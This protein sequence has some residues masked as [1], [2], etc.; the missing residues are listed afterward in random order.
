VQKESGI[1][2]EMCFEAKKVS[3]ILNPT[4]EGPAAQLRD[5]TEG[6]KNGAP[7]ELIAAQRLAPFARL[8]AEP[9]LL[10]CL[11]RF[12]RGPTSGR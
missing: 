8:P 5:E 7:P 3:R 10:K 11:T 4:I 9:V 6:K 2:N 1:L 12:F